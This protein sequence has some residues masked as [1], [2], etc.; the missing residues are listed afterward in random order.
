[1][2]AKRVGRGRRSKVERIINKMTRSGNSEKGRIKRVRGGRGRGMNGRILL[3]CKS[4]LLFLRARA[5][6]LSKL[7]FF[8]INRV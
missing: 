5:G 7:F 4:I 8:I 1:V 3:L 6:L 2:G